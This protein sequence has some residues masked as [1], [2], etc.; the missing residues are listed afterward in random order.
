[1]RFTERFLI[2]GLDDNG[3]WNKFN[4]YDLSFDEIKQKAAEVLLRTNYVGVKIIRI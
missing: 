4:I 1:M 2:E 3:K